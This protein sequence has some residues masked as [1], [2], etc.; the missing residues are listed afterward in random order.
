MICAGDPFIS[1][2]DAAAPYWVARAIAGTMM[3]LA[4]VIFAYNVFLMTLGTSRASSKWV[5]QPVRG[6]S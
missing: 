3:F 6:E 1:S 4:H 2:V 5:R